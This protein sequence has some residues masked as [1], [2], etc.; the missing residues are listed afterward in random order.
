VEE[1]MNR[2]FEDPND[3]A[4]ES[5]TWVTGELPDRSGIYAYT[6]LIRGD[7]DPE[8]KPR[9]PGGQLDKTPHHSI[10]RRLIL[11]IK[12]EILAHMQDGIPRTM[13]RIGVELWDKTA[14]ILFQT[15]VERAMWQLVEDEALAFTM[16]APVLFRV[17]GEDDG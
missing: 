7:D 2:M 10:A 12:E 15:N 6:T 16:E 13:N 11:D 3:P 8:R 5:K 17:L 4:A 9:P 1:G 14:D